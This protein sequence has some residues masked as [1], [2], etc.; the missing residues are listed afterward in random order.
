MSCSTAD[1]VRQYETLHEISTFYVRFIE[2]FAVWLSLG[3]HLVFSA[4]YDYYCVRTTLSVIKLMSLTVLS[5]L[6]FSLTLYHVPA[7]NIR[8]IEL[9]AA[10]LP[11]KI[12][13]MVSAMY[14][15]HC[16]RTTLSI[17]DLPS[18]SCCHRLSI[19]F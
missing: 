16:V 19:C 1:V 10:R 7:S 17:I 15:Y 2:S 4:I 3:A 13:L 9:I 5:I 14:D 11:L 18:P 12:Y 6:L 8:F